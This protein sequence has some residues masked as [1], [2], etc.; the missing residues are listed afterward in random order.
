MEYFIVIVVST[1]SWSK[2]API[3]SV[4]INSL[5]E[6]NNVLRHVKI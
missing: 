5:V 4:I 2:D 1:F 3:F 6:S